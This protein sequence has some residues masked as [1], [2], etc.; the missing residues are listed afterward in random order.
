MTEE[1]TTHRHGL[2]DWQRNLE[3][4]TLGQYELA[5][6]G[7]HS[8]LQDVQSGSVLVKVDLKDFDNFVHDCLPDVQAWREKIRDAE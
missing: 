5:L 3:I 2:S 7:L 1:P 4:K 8:M 6:A